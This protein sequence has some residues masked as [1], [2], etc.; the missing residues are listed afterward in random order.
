MKKVFLFLSIMVF[1][2][3]GIMFACND[4]KYADLSISIN[5]ITETSSNTA[6]KYDAEGGYYTVNYG[7][8][9]V[10]NASVKCSSD[11]NTA[12][13][14]TSL[15]ADTISHKN[16]DVNTGSGTR[17]EFKAE[18]PSYDG[19]VKIR[20]ESVETNRNSKIINVKVILPVA[21]IHLPEKPL[22]VT[23][24]IDVDIKNEITYIANNSQPNTQGYQTNEKD[25]KTELGTIT[26]SSGSKRDLFKKDENSNDYY[27][28][29][30]NSDVLAFSVNNGVIKVH[31][32][33]INGNVDVTVKSTK[34]N[35]YWENFD[36]TIATPSELEQIEK[37]EKLKDSTT[38][39]VVKPIALSDISFVGGQIGYGDYDN[40]G[41][42]NT[43]KLNAS[44]FL[45]SPSSYRNGN[46]EYYYAFENLNVNVKTETQIAIEGVVGDLT[47]LNGSKNVESDRNVLDIINPTR[48]SSVTDT[49]GKPVSYSGTVQLKSKNSGIGYVDLVV[50]FSAFANRLEFAF[51]ELYASY[52]KGLRPVELEAIPGN[53]KTT[54]LV[55]DS[56]AIAQ[57][58]VVEQDGTVIG[59]NNETVKIYDTY[60]N[61]SYAE[62]GSKMSTGL[63]LSSGASS[64]KIKDE[65]KVVRVY[66]SD[67]ETGEIKVNDYLIFRNES[68]SLFTPT[69]DSNISKYYFDLNTSTSGEFFYV[70]A[71]SNNMSVNAE[72]RFEFEN[73]ISTSITTFDG[74]DISSFPAFTT[75]TQVNALQNLSF[76]F[77]AKTV[78]GVDNI[79]VITKVTNGENDEFYKLDKLHAEENE[80]GIYNKLVLQQV[81]TENNI[82]ASQGSLIAF[83]TNLDV[84]AN[85]ITLKI[86]DETVARL[87]DEEIDVLD[88]ANRFNGGYDTSKLELKNTVSIVGL[89]I[90]STKLILTSLNGY[91]AEVEIDV[92]N[93]FSDFSI[94]LRETL[95]SKQI[96]SQ[97]NLDK[98]YEETN[99]RYY[100]SAK[101]RGTFNIVYTSSSGESGIYAVNYI[102][103]TKGIVNISNTGVVQTVTEGTTEISVEVAYYKFNVVDGFTQWTEETDFKTFTLEVYVP[104]TKIYLEHE[105]MNVYDYNTLGYEYRDFSRVVVTAVVK[106]E[107]ATIAKNL[108]NALSFRLSN[109]NKNL[110]GSNGTYDAYLRDNETVKT[111]DVIVTVNEYGNTTTLICKVTIRSASQIQRINVSAFVGDTF[112]KGT[113]KQISK[114]TKDNNDNDTYYISVK[115]GKVITFETTIIPDE[116]NVFVDDLVVSLYSSTQGNIKDLIVNK[117]AS[118]MATLSDV[119]Q[120]SLQRIIVNGQ[121]FFKLNI[122]EAKAGFFYLVIFARDSM[123]DKDNAGMYYRMLIQVTDGTMKNPHEIENAKDLEAINEAPSKHYVL[124]NNISLGSYSDW[125]PLEILTGSLNGR[126]PIIGVEGEGTQFKI[127]N[128]R[129]SSIKGEN[130]G[131]FKAIGYGDSQFGA[132]MN[133]PL[134]VTAIN[135]NNPEVKGISG[136]NIG[137]IAG[138]NNGIIYN[139][140]VTIDNF[141]IS[142]LPISA[143]IG[144]MVGQNG[145][146]IYNFANS[147]GN[148]TE[149][150]N[151]SLTQTKITTVPDKYSY[152]YV[153][154]QNP[155]NI[156]ML[157]SDTQST[158]VIVGGI[159]GVS[160]GNSVINGIY[161]LYASGIAKG[162]L[163]VEYVTTFQSQGIDVSANINVGTQAGSIVNDQSKIG[164]VVGVMLAGSQVVNLSAE[165]QIGEYNLST[166][167]LTGAKYNVG[168]IV[169]QLE[170][171]S[172]ENITSS[173]RVRGLENIGG[174][175]GRSLGGELKLVRTEALESL[176]G[177]NQTMLI[178]TNNVG[179]T[180]G[181]VESGENI[182]TLA[183]SYSFV[184]KFNPDYVNFGD[185]YS[186]NSNSNTAFGGI[187]GKSSV[188]DDGQLIIRESY[189]TFNI[190]VV[191]P[192]ASVAGILGWA[193]NSDSLVISDVFFVGVLSNLTQENEQND[194][195]SWLYNSSTN[196]ETVNGY[197][198][199]YILSYLNSKD[200][201]ATTGYD[202]FI[203]KHSENSV[204][205]SSSNALTEID[206]NA[207]FYPP[208]TLGSAQANFNQVLELVYYTQNAEGAY[209]PAEPIMLRVP[210]YIQDGVIVNFIKEVPDSISVVALGAQV[211]KNQEGDKYTLTFKYNNNTKENYF[212][213][214]KQEDGSY[215]LILNYALLKNS[216]DLKSLFDIK[217]NPEINGILNIL[218]QSN[219]K[220]LTITNNGELIVNG[221]GTFNLTFIV[222][223][224]ISAQQTVKVIVVKNFDEL[225]V[226]KDT[227]LVS[228]YFAGSNNYVNKLP[229]SAEAQNL[230]K[231]FAEYVTKELGENKHNYNK[232]VYAEF[233]LVEIANSNMYDIDLKVEYE[234]QRRE[235]N[236]EPFIKESEGPNYTISNGAIKFNT[237]GSYKIIVTVVFSQDGKDFC[238]TNDEWVIYF[239]VFAGA[240][241]IGFNQAKDIWLQGEEVYDKL[242]A[243]LT[244]DNSDFEKLAIIIEDE[245]GNAYNYDY[246]NSD[247][248]NIEDTEDYAYIPF[249]FSI[250][251][252]SVQNDVYYY[253]FAISVKREYRSVTTPVSYTLKVYDA[254][255]NLKNSPA[256]INLVIAPRKI[257]SVSGIHYAYSQTVSKLVNIGNTNISGGSTVNP[258][259]PNNQEDNYSYSFTSEPKNT[260]IAGGEGLFVVDI[261]PYYANINSVKIESS[262]GA[263]SG[264]ALQFVQLVKIAGSIV[265][266]SDSDDYYI[267]SPLTQTTGT[268]GIYLNLFSY[269]PR[270]VATL[271]FRSD[272]TSTI[273]MHNGKASIA[274]SDYMFG[275]DL[276]IDP[277]DNDYL[278]TGRLFIKTIA[279]TYLRDAESF[280]VTVTI[281]YSA[282]NE[283]NELQEYSYEYTHSIVVE[284]MPGFN[285]SIQHDGIERD[286]IAYTETNTPDWLDIVPTIDP[287]YTY[288]ELSATMKLGS[289]VVETG[290]GSD[291]FR[292]EKYTTNNGR[293]RY[294][295]TLTNKVNKA[296]Y[297]ININTIVRVSVDGFTQQ[298]AYSATVR[299]VDVV[300][301]EVDIKDTDVNGNFKITVSTS[302]QLKARI[303]GFGTQD[304]LE[305]AESRISRSVTSE[306]NI[307]YYWSV[308]SEN[309]A[310]FY[311]PVEDVDVRSSL[312]FI[313]TKVSISNEETTVTV[314]SDCL[315]YNGG[316]TFTF[317][318]QSKILVLEGSTEAGSVDMLLSVSYVY[319]KDC[320]IEFIPNDK[321]ST[322]YTAQKYFTVVVSEDSNEDNPY[323]IYDEDDLI[324]MSKAT[325]GH[326]ILM[327]NISI[328]RHTAL[329]ANFESF[330]GNNKIITL[331]S[332][333]YSTDI[334]G[335]SS[336]YTINLGLFD[337]VKTGTI[338]KNLIVALPATSKDTP[339]NLT[340][341]T[342]INFGGLCAINNGIITNC[343]VIS[344]FPP[345]SNGEPNNIT[346]K[347]YE[348][349]KYT[350]NIETGI[351]VSKRDVEANIGGL[352]G[353]NNSTGVITNSRVGRDEVEIL[354][355]YDQEATVVYPSPYNLT[356]PITAICLQ[357][358][359]NVGGF[360]ATNY[361]TIS[362]SF[363]K[364][365]QLEVLS[366]STPYIKTGGFVA[367]NAG[368]IYGSYAAGW[369]EEDGPIRPSNVTSENRKLGGGIY[370]SGFVGG[371]VY[372]NQSYIEDCY[373]NINLS[374]NLAFAGNTNFVTKWQQ[375]EGRTH[376]ISPS[377]GGFVFS[378]LSG[379]HILTS[380][381]L[382]KISSDNINTHG[383]FECARAATDDQHTDGVIED[384]YFMREKV[385]S[386]KYEHE[387][388]R[389]LSDDPVI[390]MEGLESASGTNEFLNTESFNNFSFDN[391]IDNFR[392]YTGLSNGGVWAMYKQSNNINGYPDLISANT[393]ATSV[394]VINVTKTESPDNETNKYY[395][396]YVDGYEVGSYLNPHIVSNFRQY[397]NIFKD[398]VGTE[399]QN[400]AITTKFT[401]NIR[402]INHINFSN[403]ETVYSTRIEYTSL[404][405]MTSIFDGNYLAIYNISLSDKADGNSSFGLFKDIYYA[406]VKNL[407]LV[408]DN[409]TAGNT[410]SVGALAG[411]IANT[412][413]SNITVIAAKDKPGQVTGNNY[414]GGLAGIIV[415]KDD[416]NL[417]NLSKIKSNLSIVGGKNRS[418]ITT[419]LPSSFI[420]WDRIKPTSSSSGLTEFNNNLRLH[421][422]PSGVYYAGGIAGVLDLHQTSI[423]DDM[424]EITKINAYNIFVGKFT[425][426]TIL[427]SAYVDYDHLVSIVSDY[428]GGLFGFV[429]SQTYLESSAFIARN[430]STQHFI[431]G[432]EVAGGI[433]AINLGLISQTYV[434]FDVATVNTFDENITK[435]VN[436]EL[437]G[438]SSVL[439]V[440][441]TLFSQGTA[442]Y[443]GGIAGINAGNSS[444]GTGNIIDCYSRL[445]VKNPNAI[446]VGGIAGGSFTG[447]ISNVYT[448]GSLYGNL[449]NKE[450]K[451]GSIIGEIFSASVGVPY[452]ATYYDGDSEYN[453]LSIYNIV[454]LNLWDSDDF[455]ALYNFVHRPD[456][457]T[458]KTGEI[459]SL[460]GKYRNLNSDIVED[461]IVRLSGGVYVQRYILR[462]FDNPYI[463]SITEDELFDIS[464]LG[465]ESY[466]ELWGIQDNGSPR[467]D[468]YL[469]AQLRG[470]D[471]SGEFI[472]Y[473][474]DYMALFSVTQAGQTSTLRETYFSISRWSRVIWNYDNDIKLPVLKYGYETSIVRIYTANQFLD[475][476]KEGNS[477]GKLYVIM[478]DIDFD[479]IPIT[480]ISNVFRGQLYGNNVNYSVSN[481]NGTG[482]IT[483]TR[484]PILFNIDLKVEDY[485]S[486]YFSIIQESYGAT[487]SNFNIVLRNFNI[488]FSEE[489]ETETMAS[490]FL[491]RATNSTINNIHIYASLND[492]V[493]KE[494]VTDTKFTEKTDADSFTYT[495]TDGLLMNDDKQIDGKS[496]EPYIITATLDNEETLS[497]DQKD[498]IYRYIFTRQKFEN[499][500]QEQNFTLKK[501]L[502]L[503]TGRYVNKEDLGLEGENPPVYEVGTS[504]KATT[505]ATTVGLLLGE[506][507]LS[508][509][510]NSSVNMNI[511]VV[512]NFN[513][514]YRTKTIGAIAGKNVGEIRYVVSRS[515]IQ[516]RHDLVD[517]KDGNY[518]DLYVGGVVG[519]IRGV[520]R[521]AYVKKVEITVGDEEHRSISKSLS[522][523]TYVGGIIGSVDRYTTVSEAVVG[524]A[525]YLYAN[526]SYINVY[527]SG[528][529]YVGGIIGQ[530]K[531]STGQASFTHLNDET[532]IN[533][534]TTG[535]DSVTMIGGLIG[536]NSSSNI[537]DAYNNASV[538]VN[539]QGNTG[540]ETISI[541]GI[542]GEAESDCLFEKTVND[543]SLI[544]IT[545]EKTEEGLRK[546]GTRINAGGIL[547]YA[548]GG[549]TITLSHCFTSTDITLDQEINMSIGGAIGYADRINA[550]N[551]IVLGDITLNRGK[552]DGSDESD[553]NS[554]F[555]FGQHNIGGL[556]GGVKGFGTNRENNEGVMTLSTIRD[557]A[558]GQKTNVNVGAVLGTSGAV[559]QKLDNIF[560]CEPISLVADNGYNPYI[561][562]VEQLNLLDVYKDVFNSVFVLKNTL[563][564]GNYSYYYTKYCNEKNKDNVETYGIRRGT[565]IYPMEIKD[566]WGS[567]SNDT[568]YVLKSNM[569]S[570]LDGS[571]AKGWIINAQGYKSTVTNAAAIRT[572]S[573][574]SAIVGLLREDNITLTN[575]TGA[576]IV[577]NNYGFV[578][579]CGTSTKSKFTGLE[580]ASLVLNNYGVINGSFSV[581]EIRVN[582]SGGGLVLNNGN[583]EYVGNIFS[584]YFTGT[585][586]PTNNNVK[587]AGITPNSNKG[588]VSNC[589]TMADIDTTVYENAE[590]Y[591]IAITSTPSSNERKNIFNSYYDYIAYAGNFEGQRFKAGENKPTTRGIY[592]W[593]ATLAGDTTAGMDI[594]MD[595]VLF[596]NWLVPG[597]ESELK[598]MYKKTKEF[599]TV[600]HK[601]ESRIKIDTS[602]FNYGYMT[603]NFK[604]ILASDNVIS[605]LKMLYTGNGLAE[606]GAT[607]ST[608]SFP[609]GPY[610]IK[611]A[612]ML[613]ILVRANN[614]D[615]NYNYKYYMFVKNID[616]IKYTKDT[617]W[618]KDWD[619][620]NVVFIGHLDG[621]NPEGKNSIVKNMYSTYG[622]LRALP[623]ITNVNTGDRK[624]VV[625]N[626]SFENCYSKTG[627]IAGYMS[628]N[629]LLENIIVGDFTSPT[630]ANHV[631]NGSFSD[632]LND[633]SKL[634]VDE[635]EVSEET[636]NAK[637]PVWLEKKYNITSISQITFRVKDGGSS[638]VRQF[639]PTEEAKIANN[640]N[641]YFPNNENYK[642]AGGLIGYMKGGEIVSSGGNGQGIAFS[643]LYVYASDTSERHTS[644]I[645]G[646]VGYMTG[647][648]IGSEDYVDWNVSGVSVYA[649]YVEGDES[650]SRGARSKSYVGGVVGYMSRED[651]GLTAG[652]EVINVM[653]SNSINGYY[654]LGSVVGLA[655]YGSIKNSTCN[656][657]NITVTNTIFNERGEPKQQ[658]P[659]T[660]KN[661]SYGG[662][663]GTLDKEAIVD[664]CKKISELSIKDI[665][666]SDSN[667][668]EEGKGNLGG[669]VGY[670]KGGTLT[671]NQ[672]DGDTNITA[673]SGRAYVGGIIGFLVG[674]TLGENNISRS[675]IRSESSSRGGAYAV[676]GGIIGYVK[677]GV[678]DGVT[679]DGKCSITSIGSV[680]GQNAA[681]GIIGE[682]E[683]DDVP[684]NE[685]VVTVKNVE[686]SKGR[687]QTAKTNFGSAGG[688]VGTIK[689]TETEYSFSDIIVVENCYSSSFI[690]NNN[691]TF[692]GGIVGSVMSGSGKK[693][694]DVML[695]RISSCIYEV[696]SQSG[697]IVSASGSE[698]NPSFT[699]GIVGYLKGAQIIECETKL[700]EKSVVG[701]I[702]TYVAGGIAGLVNGGNIRDCSTTKGK[703]I[704]NYAAGGTVGMVE[705]N[706]TLDGDLIKN[707]STII[708]QIAGGNIGILAG[709]LSEMRAAEVI[710]E[711]TVGEK[712]KL[713]TGETKI[714]RIAG[715][716]IGV[717]NGVKDSRITGL[718]N[719]GGVYALDP[720]FVEAIYDFTVVSDNSSADKFKFQIS[721]TS[722][723][724][725]INGA[726]G[727]V[728]CATKTLT[729]YDS[730]TYNSQGARDDTKIQGDP[731]G[732]RDDSQ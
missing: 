522:A 251:K 515:D 688:I 491:G 598:E 218:V 686:S 345:K 298:Q 429:G 643:N 421:R 545:E 571:T 509:I 122:G 463:S 445:D 518:D 667:N 417:Y 610:Q 349:V 363:A 546:L 63:T 133:L 618:S 646:L 458:G 32:Q 162:E 427:E 542:V 61:R 541:G 18:M 419:S 66:I 589:Y 45:N 520:V 225:L 441:R 375:T 447:Q 544:T 306:D 556:A 540:F 410:S 116:K 695:I 647:G 485:Q 406:G 132:V 143:D 311:V 672:V 623:V 639:A 382:S 564:T 254:N 488:Q 625:K 322:I 228:S 579:A 194:S 105:T 198:Y 574:G 28:R 11:I 561:T 671:N 152:E 273:S 619:I 484:R 369:E 96:I 64:A 241:N 403:S 292:I 70:K 557:Y 30:N 376:F 536:S 641:A 184:N 86:E 559:T 504:K 439:K 455:D 347:N 196:S 718:K 313:V 182:I 483:Y 657:P 110:I 514:V 9:F 605:Y 568:Y 4:D 108:S 527:V 160:G 366:S 56:T 693:S 130:V 118:D 223:E 494:T 23:Y 697:G 707:T 270:S 438:S 280:V 48:Y 325:E 353:I 465:E 93:Q 16:N 338:I 222:R 14:Y 721:S 428:S 495:V 190:S 620:R 272:S 401:G 654:S 188:A 652:G 607:S 525:N 554:Y 385:E 193:N 309:S 523:G 415:S 572:V 640:Q 299:V 1:A 413:V 464:K 100:A 189:S 285:M 343:D 380:Y 477:A 543:A 628:D 592:V 101:V 368:F 210:C 689:Y 119:S 422:L 502:D 425:P 694:Y 474:N 602:W 249:D 52:L 665:I 550:S 15:N 675:A 446:G 490:A 663:V 720:E 436:K 636:Q 680:T 626:I 551:T 616:F 337:V 398:A 529:A 84:D 320:G 683:V 87:F 180:I 283:N 443:I 253:S 379:S 629:C 444:Y 179:G 230:F 5:S 275:G 468:T 186:Y 81:T 266:D 296:G 580:I 157:I 470:G 526:N 569:S 169:G 524:G 435:Y 722:S 471:Q 597:D 702:N 263:E 714:S 3:T 265:A 482:S 676:A 622:L 192:D 36:K 247:L 558:L 94:A 650:N 621:K 460:Y 645:G 716:N 573:E 489:I 246:D 39:A 365:L 146:A 156:N 591:P 668:D 480:P 389:M 476:L 264:N 388:A 38:I 409:I 724:K 287:G 503:S 578:F 479:N 37:N 304:N 53:A 27:Y 361:G 34:Y 374:G 76:T 692:S 582:A 248:P 191:S 51:S 57:D 669:I 104:A 307:N 553:P 712:N 260:I 147:N 555:Y 317:K 644:Y 615:S 709:T 335:T 59:K 114:T 151:L 255:G 391:S 642:F 107:N 328:S 354:Y 492:A 231:V 726:G 678:I 586:Y 670:M 434:S 534:Y 291:Y 552:G 649:S 452:F 634:A 244:S 65:N 467:C 708:G 237:V 323:P 648:T 150:F 239:D 97:N 8:S 35:E 137:A 69:Y 677:R 426:N 167:T 728:G 392:Y 384:C 530:N 396:T 548:G 134:H 356:A 339:M 142:G 612:G 224:N 332:F 397:N 681:G 653:V 329:P 54:K 181:I 200:I 560:F 517:A 575:S 377:A 691:E 68:G 209:V 99:G 510:T 481:K 729:I 730:K 362:T 661:F 448:T 411:V 279:P 278:D 216:F 103:E 473:P 67:E 584:C 331:E 687:V 400:D 204:S 42:N 404:S 713:A 674:G 570:Q 594:Q 624:T 499:G 233:P 715:G 178:G 135:I 637:F 79:E 85:D 140:S 344:T 289:S 276:N 258:D 698:D 430:E 727:I 418:E 531:Y 682:I 655:E 451:M 394:R 355:V 302:R 123:T 704:A 238:F 662:I 547:G 208:K 633:G 563:L 711:A 372:E 314:N 154:S 82:T 386:F 71:R 257:N 364:N 43:P 532:A 166:K 535:A 699:G 171:G 684:D 89:K 690:G 106:D 437:T 731:Q 271:D 360:V 456:D 148:R 60:A 651:G 475:K 316:E 357:G 519:S 144:G 393:I 562:G 120:T 528:R 719:Y 29:T 262:L 243:M 125:T 703:I 333:N 371:F 725:N 666:L 227:N 139:C 432:D 496:S 537:E 466:I 567:L 203:I 50:Y 705:E 359:G 46:R 399:S 12:L 588:T 165:G 75:P 590:A 300:I 288:D 462:N 128:L 294:R 595:E 310:K 201:T 215:I 459:G 457:E 301:E 606:Y 346:L 599:E 732:R 420:I 664:G 507:S 195:I 318:S 501:R 261:N 214:L 511:N 22:A 334:A 112:I 600:D 700:D 158:Y 250:D 138:V 617:W 21:E 31:D 609:D 308:K 487:F 319:N 234:V 80:N 284:S 232:D 508:Y 596:G 47:P 88:Y 395:Y 25:I 685:N 593:S 566:S 124:A 330:D 277:N 44:L 433:T 506:G 305:K 129:I 423:V 73:L 631:Y 19:F 408:V 235:S 41:K 370:S 62:Y 92:V 405:N 256:T 440:N 161:G 412:N 83:L 472:I 205:A 324:E 226:G 207:S 33:T 416:N 500:T 174:I 74:T 170:N 211:G 603:N 336:N 98:T 286:I 95:G 274:Y 49:N 604:N 352:V 131:L 710:N 454:S 348:D 141:K 498:Y 281:N 55:I 7:D 58:I 295:L 175:V 342:T 450:T 402:L 381:S 290:I 565:K 24:G 407:T 632:L 576:G 117:D 538:R 212:Y 414:V 315:G 185:I 577:N 268:N 478:N 297:E 493:N 236:N 516:V 17:A 627:L 326:Y 601:D 6:L 679:K 373:S 155:V 220:N 136:V 383:A 656:N 387:R 638:R 701:S 127:T 229:V 213:S 149:D 613:D 303:K 168:G 269:I 293:T 312:P 242:V 358:R 630:T 659:G 513:S 259:N 90:G 350:I 173:V 183:Y 424:A 378:T 608:N 585:M 145:G 431:S 240:K 533:V 217:P 341:Y 252:T 539:V 673:I 102:T 390:D 172:L 583:D 442:K 109:N 126:N 367:T 549:S 121:G 321:V 176:T 505:N 164:G 197:Y 581:S 199:Y 202:C 717:F 2:L 469:Y 267:Y 340:N 635:N 10:I 177:N 163:Q 486:N 521:F 706:L 187:V 587:L 449:Q 696:S 461:G 115:N 327:N 40:D 20:I 245:D 77:N 351:I 453:I 723:N 78:K 282:I 26:L 72:F 614:N 660:L 611:H 497:T 206:Y 153:V 159:A 91:V 113:Q 13:R 658:E 111:V 221:I 219:N 512:Y